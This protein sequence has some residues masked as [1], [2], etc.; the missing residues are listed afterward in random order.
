M[1]KENVWPSKSIIC[2]K[3]FKRNNKSEMEKKLSIWK[4][5]TASRRS[6]KGDATVLF[7]S[8][9]AA[10]YRLEKPSETTVDPAYD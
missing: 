6:P 10:P 7:K 3:Q 1:K 9:R 2:C 5:F 8:C 4:K